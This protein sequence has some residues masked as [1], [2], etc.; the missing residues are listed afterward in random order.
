VKQLIAL[1]LLCLGAASA[2]AETPTVHFSGYGRE[3]GHFEISAPGDTLWAPAGL[4]LSATPDTLEMGEIF[5]RGYVSLS[6]E[7]EQMEAQ[8]VTPA[9]PRR[10]VLIDATEGLGDWEGAGA[11][12]DGANAL[13][14][15]EREL[16]R[17][18]VLLGAQYR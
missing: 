11:H 1:C 9:F 18:W 12:P 13:T 7:S 17:L 4:D 2:A 5:P 10:S 14:D 15:R 16:F 6:G 3:T 8:V